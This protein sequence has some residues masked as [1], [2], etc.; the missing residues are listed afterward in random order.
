VSCQTLNVT[1][2][3]QH[4]ASQFL[5][6]SATLADLI[7]DSRTTKARLLHYFPPDPSVPQSDD[8]PIDSWCGFHLDHSFLTGLCPVSVIIAS[9]LG[10]DAIQA[11]FL[12]K[13][14]DGEPVAIKN[15]ASNSG[16][17]IRN[18][19][20]D[21]VKVTIPSD[22]LAFQTGEALEI[23]TENRLRATPHC[24]RVGTF[25]S[26]DEISRESF[27]LF[28]QCDTKHH[29]SSDMTFGDF[30]KK[31]FSEHYDAPTM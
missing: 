20:G 26:T 25:S 5:R 16:L 30:S 12:R 24:V 23:A 29:L 10:S 27:A 3:H 8:D 6:D 21:L 9:V 13:D 1:F 15:P 31:V 2:P 17:Y 18:R 14:A 4:L 19:G 28:M 7:R 22:C 11:L